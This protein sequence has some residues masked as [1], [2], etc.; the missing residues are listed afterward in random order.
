MRALDDIERDH[1]AATIGDWRVRLTGGRIG[2]DTAA[3]IAVAE[4]GGEIASL[5]RERDAIAAVAAR[6][7]VPDLLA[8]ARRLIA[9]ARSQWE[10]T[11]WCQVCGNHRHTAD[12]PIAEPADHDDG[13][14]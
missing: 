4:R 2:T 9:A 8:L 14:E 7:D 1:R 3:V 12:C 5:M 11:G 13:D 10:E 6:T